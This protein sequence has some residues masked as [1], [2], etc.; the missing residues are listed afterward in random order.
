MPYPIAEGGAPTSGA[1]AL[2]EVAIFANSSAPATRPVL[3]KEGT[4]IWLRRKK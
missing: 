4:E 3:K 1:Q 2:R